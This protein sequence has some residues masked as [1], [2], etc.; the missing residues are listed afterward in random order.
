MPR[1][2]KLI[3]EYRLHKPTNQAIVTMPDVGG[4][5]RDIYLGRHGSDNSVVEYART[6]LEWKSAT[7][8][9]QPR[10]QSGI[11]VNEL[12]LRFWNFAEGC[13]GNESKELVA[14]RHAVRHLR[15]SFGPVEASRF[16][17]KSLQTVRDRMIKVDWCRALINRQINRIRRVFKWA[18]AE[19]LLPADVLQALQSV[20]GLAGLLLARDGVA[21]SRASQPVRAQ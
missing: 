15:R 7:E 1:H 2:K 12:I 4:R 8:S 9:D 20:R 14:Y 19:E 10:R 6:I 16:G 18:V 5:R 21:A 17:P 3:P 13:Y 11:T